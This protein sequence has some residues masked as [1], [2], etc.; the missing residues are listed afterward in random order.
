MTYGSAGVGTPLHLKRRY[1]RGFKLTISFRKDA[2]I[3]QDDVSQKPKQD[4][5]EALRI[6]EGLLPE[7]AWRKVDQG[8]IQG[9][10]IYEF[11]DQTSNEADLKSEGKT[12]TISKLLDQMES[13]KTQL[14][15]EDWGISQTS[16]EEVFLNIV[17]DE[18]ADASE[19]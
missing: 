2:E 5:S 16:L 10:A 6:I 8:G 15:I 12:G 18:D 14:D 4:R 3:A 13:L 9:S 1:G 7:G 19:N 11:D 17:R